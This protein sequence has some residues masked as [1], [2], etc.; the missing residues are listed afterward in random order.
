[1]A[2]LR[3]ASEMKDSRDKY[4][5]NIPK[6]WGITKYKYFAYSG[7][8]QTI[9]KTDTSDDGIPIYS[10]TQDSTI[11]GYMQSPNLLL[12][13][14][15]IVIPARG[16]SI[17]CPTFVNDEIATCTQTTIYSRIR[18]ITPKFL[19]YCCIGLKEEWFY[20]VQT[21]IPQIT[22]AQVQNNNVPVPDLSEQQAIADYLDDR[23]SKIDEIIA[24]ATASI[25]EYKELKQAVIFEAVTKGLDKN[26][27]MKDSGVEWIG[28]IPVDSSFVKLKYLVT[29]PIT[30]GTHQ[31]PDYDSAVDGSPFLSSKDVTKGYIDWSK[32]KY[33]T[34]KL[35]EKLHKE[36]A[37]QRDDIL[38]AKNGTTGV[39][40]IVDTDAI[41]DVYVT[42]AV[43][44]PD[45]K[46]VIPK[47]LLHAIN[48]YASKR[49]FDDHLIG[50]GVPNLHLNVINNT[51]IIVHSKETQQR[52]VDYLDERISQMDALISEKQ[53]LIDDLQAYKKSLIYEVV[54]GKRRVV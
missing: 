46:T 16:N 45:A 8:G 38:L 31:T 25:E 52:I 29:R 24:E 39:A 4:I 51:K 42:L 54:T 32:I 40:A 13:R 22:V 10:A 3:P 7:M 19:Y 21:A 1:M 20:Y 12:H 27:P 47:Y 14:G 18:N 48:S 37:P 53:A 23:C 33:I 41:F 35:H 49:Q 36:I 30:D 15:D 9:L 2:M 44:R 5:G 43:I 11:F 17:G 34:Q 50:I 26:A 28:E 6:N